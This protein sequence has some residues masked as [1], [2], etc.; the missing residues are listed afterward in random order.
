MTGR[1][2]DCGT[3]EGSSDSTVTRGGNGGGPK[4]LFC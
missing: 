4:E 1:I 2:D 3:A